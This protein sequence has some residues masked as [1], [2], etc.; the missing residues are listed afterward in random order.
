MAMVDEEDGNG[1]DGRSAGVCWESAEQVPFANSSTCSLSLPLPEAD[2]EGISEGT[3]SAS[4]TIGLR[5]VTLE[6]LLEVRQRLRELLGTVGMASS[7]RLRTISG[8]SWTMEDRRL[9][10]FKILVRTAERR[11]CLVAVVV[12]GISG[13]ALGRSALLSWVG[14]CEVDTVDGGDLLLELA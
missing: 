11:E 6:Y 13:L 12:G 14:V 10:K 1:V 7:T 9:T 4:E 2:V 5:P 8:L 3:V